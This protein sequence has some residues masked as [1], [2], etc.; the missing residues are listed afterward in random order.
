[1]RKKPISLPYRRKRKGK[2]NYKKRLKLLLSSK[3]RLVIR[4]FLKNII[5]QIIEYHPKGDKTIAA[6]HSR[7]LEKFDWKLSKGN[8]SA[9]YLTGLLLGKKAAKK[10]IKEVIL[11]IGLHTPTKGSRIFACLKG[12]LDA[13]ISVPFSED[14]LPSKERISGQHIAQHRKLNELPKIFEETKNK[15]LKV[16]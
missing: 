14:I 13:G 10:N 12:V 9:A 5:A 2:T 11:D 6:V 1:M 16:E 15:I 4:P 3:P 8:V 7:E